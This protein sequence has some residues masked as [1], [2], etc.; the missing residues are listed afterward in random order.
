[1]SLTKRIKGDFTIETVEYG[2]SIILYPAELDVDNAGEVIIQGDLTVRGNTTTLEATDL[3]V[4]DNTILL[5]SG[6][7]GPGITHI[8][9]TAGINIDRGYDNGDPDTGNP[10]EMAGIRFNET[11]DIWEVNNG[12]GSWLTV[13]TGTAGILAV[14]EDTDPHLGGALDVNGWTITS[15]AA[16]DGTSGVNGPDLIIDADATGAVK[17]NHKLS[18]EHES[19]PGTYNEIYA[20][21]VGTAGTGLYTGADEELVS[22]TKA[23]AF[24]LIF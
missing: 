1:M 6:D 2:D 10:L 12:D 15:T 14:V 24:S 23:I 17:I 9:G 8:D 11:S 4:V 22:K 19:T 16:S 7:D 3:V 5:N 20:D 18:L 21:A 13:V